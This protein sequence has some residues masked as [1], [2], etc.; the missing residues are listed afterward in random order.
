MI[1]DSLNF[2]KNCVLGPSGPKIEVKAVQETVG[3]SLRGTGAREGRAGQFARAPANKSRCSFVDFR[4]RNLLESR[5]YRGRVA[6]LGEHLLCKRV[7]A[8][9]RLLPLRSVFNVFNNFGESA[10]RSK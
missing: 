4:E 9:Q 7:R 1:D 10:S 6:Q 2:L 8:L 5:S 3:S